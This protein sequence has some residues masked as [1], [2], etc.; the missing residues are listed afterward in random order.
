MLPSLR[1]WPAPLA[2]LLSTLLAS[3]S[4]LAA[5]PVAR[6]CA[7]AWHKALA[8]LSASTGLPTLLVAAALVVVGYRI[9]RRTARVALEVAVVTAALLAAS[10]AGWIRW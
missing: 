8:W 2:G 6:T 1:A 4:S 3:W 5:S 10:Q 9:L 7:L